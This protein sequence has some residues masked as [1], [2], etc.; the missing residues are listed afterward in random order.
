MC[1]EEGD[2]L[3]EGAR[4]HFCGI[5]GEKCVTLRLLSKAASLF[6]KALFFGRGGLCLRENSAMR[7]WATPWLPGK[8]PS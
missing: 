8:W 3:K 7:T 6:T 4:E 2:E 5:A 1:D